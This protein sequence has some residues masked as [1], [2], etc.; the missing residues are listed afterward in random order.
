MCGIAGK[1]VRSGEPAVDPKLV[2]HMTAALSHRGPDAQGVWTASGIGLGSSRLAVI[3]L[4]D[5]ARQPLSNEDGSIRLVFNGEIYN[6]RELRHEL[7]MRGHRFRSETD[8]E[9]IVHLYEDEGP[10]CVRKLDGMFAFALWDARTRTL[11]LAR[12]RLGQKPL[13]YW[14]RGD[15]VVFGSE[16]KALLQDT[17]VPNEVDEE[18]IHHYLTYGY[19]PAPLSAFKNIRKLA[20]AHYML[21]TDGELR[22]SRYWTL[23]YEPKLQG[24]MGD[25]GVELDALLARS[26][27]RRLVADVPLGALLSGGLDSSAVVALM[28]RSMSGTIK[29]FSIGFEEPEYDELPYARAVAAAFET[30]HHELVVKPAVTDFLPRLVYHYNEPFADS[31]ALATWCLTEM[32][33]RSVTVALSG[34][35]GDEAFLGYDRYA[36]AVLAS[37]LDCLP[38]VLRRQV[39]SAAAWLP[40]ATPKTAVARLRRFVGGLDL[41]PAQRYGRWMSMLLVEHKLKLYTPEFTAAWGESDSLGLMESHWRSA[42]ALAVVERFAHADVGMYLPD[43]LLV[44]MDIAS[45]A[46]SLEVRSPLLDHHVVEFAASLPVSFKLRL[47]TP[48]YLLRRVMR[49]YLPS[50]ILTRRKMGFGVPIDQWLRGGMRELAR[51]LLLGRTAT[52]RGYFEPATLQRYLDE[53]ES[54]QAQHHMRIWGLIM[55]ELWHRTFIDRRPDLDQTGAPTSLPTLS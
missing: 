25:L 18:A 55:L 47:G 9:V 2:A 8:T 44:K 27:E 14:H 6:F 15:T 35:G 10:E 48:K 20:P 54:G 45:M 32:A 50:G 22:L 4:S 37:R 5:R 19:V 12:D 40:A 28:R 26:V 51:D 23:D 46:N 31:S 34:D 39:A 1:L 7:E 24:S 49:A 11:M 43:D 3:D 29:T 42:N 17:T 38:M 52:E 21:V 33:G 30:E 16:P 13:F 41:E 36:G 53:H